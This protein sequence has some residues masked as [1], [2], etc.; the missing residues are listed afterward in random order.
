LLKNEESYGIIKELEAD[1]NNMQAM[2]SLALM[3]QKCETIYFMQ[4]HV[5]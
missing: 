1:I 2:L 5:I 3:S 4:I